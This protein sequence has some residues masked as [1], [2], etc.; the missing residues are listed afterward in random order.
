MRR[1]AHDAGRPEF[2]IRAMLL[3]SAAFGAKGAVVS[4]TADKAEPVWA[5]GGVREIVSVVR[6]S[7]GGEPHRRQ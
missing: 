6:R 3:L 5:A 2:A 1:I 4:C 7:A